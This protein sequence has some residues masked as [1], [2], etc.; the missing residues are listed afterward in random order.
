MNITKG[1][2]KEYQ[3]VI[4]RTEE[5][6]ARAKLL[7]SALSTWDKKIVNKS[8]FEHYFT[9]HDTDGEIHKDWKGKIV[10]DFKFI[11]MPYSHMHGKRIHLGMYEYVEVDNT[12]TMHVCE[13]VK[14]MI[15]ILEERIAH[16]KKSIEELEAVNEEA[17]TKDLIAVWKKHGKP[18]I[19]SKLLDSY[20]VQNPE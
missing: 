6:I 5:A 9:M 11:D 2:I 10:T 3:E 13:R 19:W 17:I 20:D 1:K 7:Y 14:K 15:A 16:Y 4:N 8:F 18:S 12:D